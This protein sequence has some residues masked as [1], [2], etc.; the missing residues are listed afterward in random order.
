MVL[1][2]LVLL[3]HFRETTPLLQIL[4][5]LRPCHAA[6]PFEADLL[7]EAAFEVDPFLC[8]VAEVDL[9]LQSPAGE[10][11][12]LL[13]EDYP[14][15]AHFVALQFLV[16]H[17]VAESAALLLSFVPLP[18]YPHSLLNTHNRSLP[19]TH[20]LTLPLPHKPIL[21]LPL[22]LPRTLLNWASVQS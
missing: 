13:S 21:N 11:D 16:A 1:P 3:L 19:N 15:E 5:L 9:L 18:T 22:H 6:D 12:L 20:S 14:E 7:A 17:L 8:L 2:D 4:A 10:L